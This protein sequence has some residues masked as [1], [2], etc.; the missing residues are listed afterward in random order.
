V[1]CGGTA[2]GS[3]NPTTTYN[4]AQTTYTAP[5]AIPPGGTR[6]SDGDVGDGSDEVATTSIAITAAAAT[7]ANGTYVFQ[8]AG[9]PGPNASFL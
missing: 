6:G 4:E 3:F 1:T 8:I 5:T 9:Q 2:C 7:L